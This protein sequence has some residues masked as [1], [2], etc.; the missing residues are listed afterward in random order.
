MPTLQQ[1]RKLSSVGFPVRCGQQSLGEN[2]LFL[3]GNYWCRW[4]RSDEWNPL[5]ALAGEALQLQ[6]RQRSTESSLCFCSSLRSSVFSTGDTGVQPVQPLRC[7]TVSGGL[8][9]VPLAFSHLQVWSWLL[10]DDCGNFYPTPDSVKWP[11]GESVSL[12][13]LIPNYCC[14]Q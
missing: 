4:E 12:Q 14:F 2:V 8:V 1:P 6:S 11:K 5:P 13:Y 10:E 3:L 7:S 9:G